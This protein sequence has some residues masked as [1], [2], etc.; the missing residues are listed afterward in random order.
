MTRTLY[1]LLPTTK[2]VF[3]TWNPV[4]LGAAQP[5]PARR[6]L[7]EVA[8]RAAD[9]GFVY[10]DE[11]YA[12]VTRALAAKL[13]P[14]LLARNNPTGS[15]VERGLFG[16]E[17]YYARKIVTERARRRALREAHERVQPQVGQQ[18][19]LLQFGHDEPLLG[20]TLTGIQAWRLT[21]RGTWRGEPMTRSCT[22]LEFEEVLRASR[23]RMERAARLRAP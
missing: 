9:E 2:A 14:E 4:V 17:L 20:V 1:P 22:A 10:A 18:F 21:F 8:Q 3:D 6:E 15:R 12:Y 7:I 19:A 11:I 16:Y 23:A 5:D 13:T